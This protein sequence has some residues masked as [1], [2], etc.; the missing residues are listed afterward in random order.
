MD[1]GLL[2]RLFHHLYNCDVVEEDVYH[3]WKED[4]AQDFPGKKKALSQVRVGRRWLWRE[5][6]LYQV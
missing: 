3:C 6:R 2:L 1:A 4:I 5:G